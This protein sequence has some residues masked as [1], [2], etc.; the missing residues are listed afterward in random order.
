MKVALRVLFGM[1][2]VMYPILV[3]T[4]LQHFNVRVIALLLLAVALVRFA[5]VKRT[6][7]AQ[8]S[9]GWGVLLVAI[10]IALAALVTN[11]SDYFLYYPVAMNAA[12][13]SSEARF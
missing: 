9:G 6:Q 13:L 12:M 4:G 2:M 10:L 5:V 11:Q 3:Y 7:A 8:P 1:L